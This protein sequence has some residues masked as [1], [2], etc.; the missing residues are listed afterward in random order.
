MREANPSLPSLP[1]KRFSETFFN[2][3]PLLHRWSGDHE[4]AFA[5]FMQYKTR[6]PVC[7]AIM[8]ND[9]WDKVRVCSLY[10]HCRP[11]RPRQVVLVKGWKASAGWGFPKGKINESEA[12]DACA[13]REV[14]RFCDIFRP[15][16][17]H[18]RRRCLKRRVTI[19]LVR[20]TRPMSSRSPSENNR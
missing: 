15:V 8:L 2:A 9:T 20:L 14:S 17:L 18:R 12:A 7:G 10:C 6:V 3:C 5:H 13:V 11:T 16:R 19:S 4:G 1:L